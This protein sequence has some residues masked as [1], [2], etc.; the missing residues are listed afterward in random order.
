MLPV[1]TLKGR[2]QTRLAGKFYLDDIVT[3]PFEYRNGC[4][5]VPDRPGLGIELDPAKIAEHRV[6]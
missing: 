6:A 4:L 3:E 1:T 5:V 2:D